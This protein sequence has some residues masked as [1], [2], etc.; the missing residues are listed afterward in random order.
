MTTVTLNLPESIL[1]RANKAGALAAVIVGTCVG[2]A[3]FW[4]AHWGFLITAPYL[5]SFLHRN[6]L[7][8]VVSFAA[9]VVVSLRTAPPSAEVLS[10]SFQF[11]FISG[12]GETRHDL[13]TAAA[14]MLLL[15]LIV[16]TLWWVFR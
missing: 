6:F 11:R 1:R 7:C 9:L 16:T 2:A 12:E 10:G 8:A 15:F 3:L 4:D 14:W 13:H 5:K